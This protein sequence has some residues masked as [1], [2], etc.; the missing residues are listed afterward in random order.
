[1]LLVT[2]TSTACYITD[3]CTIGAIS[4]GLSRLYSGSISASLTPT[5]SFFT[6]SSALSYFLVKSYQ[7]PHKKKQIL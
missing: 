5:F 4:S 1:M 6:D 2:P 7:S 3:P